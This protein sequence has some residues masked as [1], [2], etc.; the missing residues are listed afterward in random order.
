MDDQQEIPGC[1]L[2]GR[3]VVDR[4]AAWEELAPAIIDRA[5]TAGGLRVRFRRDPRAVELL[6]ALVDAEGEC[7]GWAAWE[8][9]EED[10]CA[11]LRVTGPAEKMA[12]LARAFGL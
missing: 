3:E 7:C 9:V 2:S 4:R 8:L 10:T 11:V 12:G 1:T 5:R 6:H